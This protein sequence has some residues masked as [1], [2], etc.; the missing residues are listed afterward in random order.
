MGQLSGPIMVRRFIQTATVAK[1]IFFLSLLFCRPL[2]AVG[3]ESSLP[4]PAGLASAVE[5]WQQV[6]AVHDSATVLFFD[7]FDHATMYS[8]LRASDDIAARSAI[9]KERARIVA[10]YDLNEEDGRLRTQR[11]VKEQF[12]SGLQIAGRYLP[13]MKRIFR[14]SGLPTDL[15]YLPLVESSFN[16]RARSPVGAAGIWQFMPETGKKFLR[17]DDAVDERLDPIA[18]TRAAA[19]LLKQNYQILG[20]WPLAVTAYNHG[21]EGMLRA[22]ET[23]GSRNL[24]DMIRRYKSPTF[25]FASQNFYAELLAVVHLAK[26]SERYFPF[27]RLQQPTPLRELTLTQPVS[28][29]AILKAAAVEPKTFLEWN[30]A[31]ASTVS[32]LPAG[33]R[34]N[35]APAKF[36]KVMAAAERQVT[37]AAQVKKDRAQAK[38]VTVA[39]AKTQPADKALATARS[40]STVTKATKTSRTNIRIAAVPSRFKLAKARN[41][42]SVPAS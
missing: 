39:A 2:F 19:R 8:T 29:D 6:F 1:T 27:L 42:A 7:P 25:G 5:F 30:P 34:I 17:I 32:K 26:N 23:T 11:G 21:T 40:G 31:I 3:F 14:E 9:D 13:E 38:T 20:S 18:S 10:E 4:T 22:I 37:G 33:S 28:V 12:L 36:A 35:V 16:L 24:T 41:A 15:A